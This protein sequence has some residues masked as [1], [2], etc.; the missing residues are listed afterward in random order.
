MVL[1]FSPVLF[2]L[3]LKLNSVKLRHLMLSY[4]VLTLAFP[5]MCPDIILLK[6]YWLPINVKAKILYH[7]HVYLRKFLYMIVNFVFVL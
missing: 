1:E 2:R 5:T 4:T 3:T 6:I 7:T